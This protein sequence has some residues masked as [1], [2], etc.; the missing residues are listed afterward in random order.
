[1]SEIQMLVAELEK[2][3]YAVAGHTVVTK[4]EPGLTSVE[5]RDRMNRERAGNLLRLRAIIGEL[6]RVTGA[7]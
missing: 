3:F 2:C 7:L 5:L 1:M 4:S 6:K